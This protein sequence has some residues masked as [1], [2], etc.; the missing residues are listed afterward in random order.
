MATLGRVFSFLLGLALLLALLFGLFEILR[1]LWSAGSNP[2]IVATFV[3]AP[4]LQAISTILIAVATVALFVVTRNLSKVTAVQ[5][6]GQTAPL[7]AFDAYVVRDP[8]DPGT[9]EAA[10]LPPYEFEADDASIV[11]IN[12][13]H[14]QFG[15][16]QRAFDDAFALGEGAIGDRPRRAYLAV[17]TYN[18]QA[19]SAY[20]FAT[21][22]ELDI[23]LTFP[24]ISTIQ[25]GSATTIPQPDHMYEIL[26]TLKIPI[27][28]GQDRV[29]IA[30]FRVDEVPFW[31]YRIDRITY[32]DFRGRIG[33]F[34]VGTG[35][36][37]FNFP[38]G[39]VNE[40]RRWE[41]GPGE[42]PK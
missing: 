26:R 12:A 28:F 9:E 31:S 6:Y 38:R 3:E 11:E 22:V 30:A 39:L 23:V 8:P 18:G 19:L 1:I 37:N 13:F 15:E 35:V 7:I 21:D 29:A 17:R 41:P 4:W 33:Y 32:R 14:R 36:G 25:G 2:R 42:Q 10:P 5:V 24:R 27:L 16:I 20:G 40:T 34:A